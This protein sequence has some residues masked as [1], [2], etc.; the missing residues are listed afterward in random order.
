MSKFA[1]RERL[2][3]RVAKFMDTEG[4]MEKLQA[5]IGR[6]SHNG[7]ISRDHDYQEP[8]ALCMR[9]EGDARLAPH[10]GV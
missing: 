1:A 6:I 5:V 3:E 4:L 9:G 10:G 2:I 7:V 8:K